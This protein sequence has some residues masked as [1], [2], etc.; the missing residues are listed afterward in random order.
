VQAG[1]LAQ[2]RYH[3][4]PIAFNPHG[5]EMAEAARR[6]IELI[7]A[8][9]TAEPQELLAPLQPAAASGG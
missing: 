1:D 5:G 4:R 6:V 2:A 3:L 7:D 9:T 8:G